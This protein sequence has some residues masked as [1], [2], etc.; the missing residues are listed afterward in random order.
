MSIFFASQ[1]ACQVSDEK[2]FM[3]GEFDPKITKPS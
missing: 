3:Y 2:D 1:K